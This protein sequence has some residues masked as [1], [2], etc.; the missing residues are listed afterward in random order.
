VRFPEEPAGEEWD[1]EDLERLF[2][3]LSARFG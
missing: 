2:P 1:E 3:R